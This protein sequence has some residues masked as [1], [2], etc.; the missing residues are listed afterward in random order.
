[1]N[2]IDARH[3]RWCASEQWA[4]KGMIS[5]LGNW[6]TSGICWNEPEGRQAPTVMQAFPRMIITEKG[7]ERIRGTGLLRISSAEVETE[8]PAV[9]RAMPRSS[10]QRR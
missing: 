3:A 8:R 10:R 7:L 2:E 4:G 1:M 9:A 6:F 5:N